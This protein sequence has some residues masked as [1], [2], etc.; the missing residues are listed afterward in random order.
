M[1]Q[2]S[3][4]D[5]SD[6]PPPYSEVKNRP[7]VYAATATGK[8]PSREWWQRKKTWIILAV[9][10]LAIIGL[11]VGLTVGSAVS[12]S[13][14]KPYRPSS[15]CSGS[16][17]PQVITT[18]LF[19]TRL[20]VFIRAADN[21]I[22]WNVGGHDMMP[23]FV[24]ANA[25]DLWFDVGD[26]KSKFSSQPA[27]VAWAHDGQPR[28]SVFAVSSADNAVYGSYLQDEEWSA[29]E[30]VG[31]NAG[32]QPVLCQVGNGTKEY[33]D[34]WV[35]DSESHEVMQQYWD[36]D[37]DRWSVYDGFAYTNGTGPASTA[38][39]VACR[40][41]DTYDVVWYGRNDGGA[42]WHR[43]YNS[44]IREWGEPRGFGGSFVGN[45]ALFAQEQSP[46]RIDFFGVQDNHEVYHFTRN[47]T[48]FSELHSLGGNVTSTPSVT[49]SV[50]GGNYTMEVVALGSDGYV[51][52]Q[53]YNGSAWYEDW[54]N[55]NLSAVGAPLL[56]KWD[57]TLNVLFLLREDGL[58]YSTIEDGETNWIGKMT[59][60]PI[61]G[62]PSLG[63][64]GDDS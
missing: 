9:V 14:H 25:M 52:H 38:P 17:C 31:P 46:Q 13:K 55:L 8:A 53:Q 58:Y 63:F 61:G 23:D 33:I 51:R 21:H 57:G 12:N 6:T 40:D 45:P 16:I 47:G 26:I 29:W 20:H 10:V 48:E 24:M 30:Q 7:P 3:E 54:E 36:V 15:L 1:S 35:T 4:E 43:G 5:V 64:F 22:A 42:L 60:S 27:A 59:M 11:V 34:M 18:A 62:S 44:T 39:A 56:T 37:K 2:A 28:L 32:S 41:D 19:D 50:A 49:G